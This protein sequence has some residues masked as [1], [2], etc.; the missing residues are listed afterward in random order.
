MQRTFWLNVFLNQAKVKI[1]NDEGYRR[2]LKPF[3]GEEEL[4]SSEFQM[5][6]P[7]GD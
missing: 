7:R 1:K 2:S 3:R 4:Q 6:L 5:R